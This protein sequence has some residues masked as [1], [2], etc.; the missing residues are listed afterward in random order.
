M[1]KESLILSQKGEI[2][3]L[4]FW[5]LSKVIEKEEKESLKMSPKW[6]FEKEEK[7]SLKV[8]NESLKRRKLS[9]WN[10]PANK[11]SM[12]QQ[13]SHRLKILPPCIKHHYDFCSFQCPTT[14]EIQFRQFPSRNYTQLQK[15]N[16]YSF[17]DKDNVLWAKVYIE[18]FF[19]S[20]DI[21][22]HF[23]NLISW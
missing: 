15:K 18:P 2:E 11:K 22:H 9:H 21:D 14:D 7:E 16:C 13:K 1:E 5:N 10:F 23:K 3:S 8:R 4:T 12:T 6:G 19:T 17:S 20:T